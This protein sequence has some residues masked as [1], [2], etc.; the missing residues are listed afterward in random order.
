MAPSPPPPR[1]DSRPIDTDPL[2][3]MHVLYFWKALG[4]GMLK[5]MFPGVLHANTQTQIHKYSVYVTGNM[6]NQ[7][8]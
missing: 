3:T 7:L 6:G 1:A 5:M 8:L 2:W 4:T